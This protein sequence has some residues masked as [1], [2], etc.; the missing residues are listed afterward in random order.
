MT[1][2]IAITGIGIVC[3]AGIG[4]EEVLKGNTDTFTVPTLDHFIPRHRSTRL[5]N[6]TI[7]F[8]CQ[9]LCSAP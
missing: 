9:N 4:L 2:R 6:S 3:S 8:Y 5:Q 1:R 7:P